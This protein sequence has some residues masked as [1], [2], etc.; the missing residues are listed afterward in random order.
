MA[1]HRPTASYLLGYS[2]NETSA[3]CILPF[4]P[5]RFQYIAKLLTADANANE[6][7]DKVRHSDL[8]QCKTSPS[9]ILS[10]DVIEPLK[11]KTFSSTM[12]M[13][14]MS[15]LL[16][17]KPCINSDVN[18]DGNRIISYLIVETS[19]QLM[20]VE[21]LCQVDTVQI[22][23]DRSISQKFRD[24]WSKR[25]FQY[26]GAI[27]LNLAITA[28]D[29]LSDLLQLTDVGTSPIRLLDPTCGSGTFLAFATMKWSGITNCELIGV[30][31]NPNCAY[32][33]VKNLIKTSAVDQESVFCNTEKSNWHISFPTNGSS[34][35][36]NATIV[37]GDSTQINTTTFAGLFDCAVTNLPWNR[38]T[39]EYK[40]V[41]LF[42]KECGVDSI[43]K[44]ILT[45]VTSVMKSR[46]PIVVVSAGTN[47]DQSDY[48]DVE[49]YLE[50]M[51]YEV[52][53]C[54][55]VPPKA[56]SLPQ[57]KKKSKSPS[58]NILKR[59]SNCSIVVALA[60]YR[61]V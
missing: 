33:T 55:S 39:F 8:I 46:A 9:W 48:F 28:I 10:H 22:E 32:G 50:G 4:R 15:R 40:G 42:E 1:F 61:M 7:L 53:G 18:S 19:S 25:P 24:L 3:Q 29:I 47:G 35:Q 38:N 41:H 49:K 37:T 36:T 6:L 14:A 34:M 59:T 27:N 56:F 20:L 44:G 54:A 13:C 12:L 43:N 45:A 11:P 31:S 57:T 51:G 30:D 2:S 21:K 23:H 58:S 16:P 17:G 52:L 26:S 60:P 5:Y